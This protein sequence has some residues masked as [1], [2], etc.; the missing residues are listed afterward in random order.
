MNCCIGQSGAQ[1]FAQNPASLPIPVKSNR[2]ME[3]RVTLT[4]CGWAPTAFLSPLPALSK[5]LVPC[6][7]ERLNFTVGTYFTQNLAALQEGP[8]SKVARR[9]R[10]LTG[11]VF[12]TT[13]ACRHLQRVVSAQLSTT[14]FIAVLGPVQL[15]SHPLGVDYGSFSGVPGRLHWTSIQSPRMAA[16]VGAVYKGQKNMPVVLRWARY[17]LEDPL[18]FILLQSIYFGHVLS[19]PCQN[20]PFSAQPDGSHQTL[21]HIPPP[22]GV[23]SG[24]RRALIGLRNHE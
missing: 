4:V 1:H 16:T 15:F 9:V 21:V 3:L 10:Y 17:R 19:I 8:H 7:L 6:A 2:N 5:L 11:N 12:V 13:R 14:R 24:R 23:I 18:G 20:R 22:R